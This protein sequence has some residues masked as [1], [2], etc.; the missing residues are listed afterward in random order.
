[1]F[2]LEKHKNI[3]FCKFHQF[4]HL[5]HVLLIFTIISG[6]RVYF[7]ACIIEHPL[8]TQLAPYLCVIV[9]ILKSES[10]KNIFHQ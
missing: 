9:V 8:K 6:F 4:M 1:M 7:F 3:F 10:N 5:V 2:M